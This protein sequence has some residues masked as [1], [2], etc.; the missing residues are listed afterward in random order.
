MKKI[1]FL[2]LFPIFCQGQITIE[3]GTVSNPI[4]NNTAGTSP[5]TITLANYTGEAAGDLFVVLGACRNATATIAVSDA[6]GQNWTSETVITNT[7]LSLRLFWCVYNGSFATTPSFSFSTATATTLTSWRIIP[8][9]GLTSW[10]VD[11]AQQTATFTAPSTPF[12][13]TRAGQTTVHNSTISLAAWATADDNTWGTIS[14]SGWV[15]QPI[16]QTRNLD[17]SDLSITSATN[18]RTTQGSVP[19]V[20]LNQTANGGDA[21]VTLIITFYDYTPTAHTKGNMFHVFEPEPQPEPVPLDIPEKI[22]ANLKPK[23]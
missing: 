5:L 13:V 14:G 3:N 2:L 21:G 22:F 4:D 17:G 8:S 15:Q 19:N 6:G 1:L 20:S 12:T 9:S 23:E 10:A 7:N 11:V 16:A 18:I